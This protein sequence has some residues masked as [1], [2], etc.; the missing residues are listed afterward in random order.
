MDK[1]AFFLDIDGTLTSAGGICEENILAI[2]KA[3]E[4]G[5]KIFINS[6]RSMGYVPGCVREVEFDGYVVGIGCYVTYGDELLLSVAIPPEEVAEMFEKFTSEGKEVVLEGETQSFRNKY[7]ENEDFILLENGKEYLE[8]YSDFRIT[9]F[10]VPFNFPEEEIN[11]LRR[12]YTAF[13]HPTYLEYAP[14]GYSKATGM[15]MLLQKCN[16]PRERCVAIGDSANDID[17]LNYAGI[18]VAVGNAQDE[19]KAICTKITAPASEGGV[20]KAICEILGISLQE[21]K[22]LL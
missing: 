15:E 16:I 7:N 1:Y 18:S 14:K 11:E 20:G 5:H 12:R 3:R 2:K 9:K 21:D 19:I 4:L 10:F 13:Q 8:K 22:Q 17:M 6:G